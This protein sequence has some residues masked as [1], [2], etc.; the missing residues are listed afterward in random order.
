MVSRSLYLVN[1]KVLGPFGTVQKTRTIFACGYSPIFM[2]LILVLLFIMMATISGFS[3]RPLRGNIPL[4]GANSLAI[5]AVCH[6]P[7]FSEAEVCRPLLWGATKQAEGDE[8]G[9]CALSSAEVEKPLVG[10]KYW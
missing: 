8:P 10:K 2:L 1:I 3:M 7:D 4:I 6:N 5:S 9:H